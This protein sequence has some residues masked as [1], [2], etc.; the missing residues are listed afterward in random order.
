MNVQV[1]NIQQWGDETLWKVTKFLP[2]N[3]NQ[4]LNI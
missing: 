4:I 2:N 3:L 1:G